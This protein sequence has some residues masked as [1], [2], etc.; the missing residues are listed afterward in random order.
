M[1]ISK[2]TQYGKGD[3]FALNISKSEDY[4]QFLIC[5]W[6]EPAQNFNNGDKVVVEVDNDLTPVIYNK[7]INPEDIIG[8]IVKETAKIPS[9]SP[10][11]KETITGGH[12]IR[13]F[14]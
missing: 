3:G 11:Y 13:E 9:L 12:L 2:Y 5:R 14:I 1:N 8:Y 6:N 7:D 4:N 10:R